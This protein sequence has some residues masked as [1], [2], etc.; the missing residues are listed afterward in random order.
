M[1][2]LV[3]LM[4]PGNLGGAGGAIAAELLSLL[5]WFFLLQALCCF[6]AFLQLQSNGSSFFSFFG[7]S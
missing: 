5:S 4:T 2:S 3:Y 1:K 7:V 6:A